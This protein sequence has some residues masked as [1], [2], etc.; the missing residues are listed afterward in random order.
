MASIYF[1]GVKFPVLLGSLGSYFEPFLDAASR[2]DPLRLLGSSAS[3]AKLLIAQ[4][5]CKMIPILILIIEF[6]HSW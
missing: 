2:P 4:F 3:L 1:D 5:I 6:A